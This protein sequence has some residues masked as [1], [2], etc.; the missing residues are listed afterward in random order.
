MLGK[1][2]GR[3]WDF[4]GEIGNSPVARQFTGDTWQ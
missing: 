3:D 4:E 1:G 2:E